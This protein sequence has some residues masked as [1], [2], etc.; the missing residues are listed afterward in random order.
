MFEY[1][2]LMGM[3]KSGLK[4]Q[5]EHTFFNGFVAPMSNYVFTTNN[6]EPITT[7]YDTLRGKAEIRI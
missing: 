1:L 4:S 2:L 5:T 3:K 7:F 6:R